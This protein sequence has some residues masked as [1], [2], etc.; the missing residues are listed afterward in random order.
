[1]ASDDEYSNVGQTSSSKCGKAGIE[2]EVMLGSLL[3]SHCVSIKAAAASDD[4]PTCSKR[5][6]CRLRAISSSGSVETIAAISGSSVSPEGLATLTLSLS[7]SLRPP[8]ALRRDSQP[9][10]SRTRVAFRKI[11]SERLFRAS[12]ALLEQID[13]CNM[14][15]QTRTLKRTADRIHVRKA[16]KAVKVRLTEHGSRVHSQCITA[17]PSR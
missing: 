7:L 13:S 15:Q 5:R 9:E 10:N 6:S 17:R 4:V 12:M 3:A 11:R 14:L 16:C 8:F 1:M 2:A